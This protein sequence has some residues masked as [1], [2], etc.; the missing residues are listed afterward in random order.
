MPKLTTISKTSAYS[1]TLGADNI[2]TNCTALTEL[3][4][5]TA[6]KTAIEATTGYATKWWAPS[7]CTIYFDL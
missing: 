5:W 2:F 6:N 1:S 3:H 7:T 4:F